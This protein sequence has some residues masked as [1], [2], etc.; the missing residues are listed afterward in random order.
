M[1]TIK[2]DTTVSRT[3]TPTDTT[4]PT[5]HFTLEV[6]SD[7]GIATLTFD[8]PDS[9]VN[10]FTREAITELD[11]QLSEIERRSAGGEISGVIFAG[12]KKHNFIAGADI[13]L[14]EAITGSSEGE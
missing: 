7:T 8:S 14:I 11:A 2:E 12:A 3:E 9:S 5:T 13:H 4:L 1:S 6:E 10:T